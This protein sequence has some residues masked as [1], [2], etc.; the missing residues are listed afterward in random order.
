MES[1]GYSIRDVSTISLGPHAQ[2]ETQKNKGVPPILYFF[3]GTQKI[4]PIRVN[5]PPITVHLNVDDIVQINH[6]LGQFSFKIFGQ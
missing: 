1:E 4:R 2:T 3:Q 6:Y 5:D